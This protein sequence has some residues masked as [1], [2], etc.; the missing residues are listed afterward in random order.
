MIHEERVKLLALVDSKKPK[1]PWYFNEYLEHLDGENSSPNTL[2]DYS[3]DIEYFIDWLRAE[4]Y[5]TGPSEQLPIEVLEK[6]KVKDIISYQNHCKN[7]LNNKQNTIARKLA[8]LKSWFHYLSQIAEDENLYP[9]LKRNVMAKVKITKEKV[10]KKKQASKIAKSILLGNEFHEFR[11]FIAHDYGKL[12]EQEKRKHSAYIHNR[13]RDLAFFSLIL[14]SGLRASEALSINVDNIDWTKNRV[15]V[16]RKGGVE[17]IVSFSDLA[18]LDL[19]E[20]FNIRAA[21]Y[22]PSPSEKALFLSMPTRSG[23]ASRMQ[24]RSLQKRFENYIRKYEKNTLTVHKL[25]HSFATK[26]FQENNNLAMLQ[27]ILNHSDINT[28]MIYTHILSEDMHDSVN[29]ADK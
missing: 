2:L 26:H 17:D 3:Y 18:A 25:R 23:V 7:R 28:T 5:F 29:K 6:L 14:G 12:I 10:S 1:M 4:H 9:Y 16:I 20:Y 21:R 19:R 11:S 22:N 13:E 27:E 15:E 24:L 8:S